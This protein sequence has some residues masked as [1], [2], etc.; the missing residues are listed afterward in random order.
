MQCIS[1][2]NGGVK[3]PVF[4][5]KG[6][7]KMADKDLK[8]SVI[9]KVALNIQAISTNTTTAGAIIDTLG[10]ESVTFVLQ[11]G[12]LTD[13]AYTPLIEDGD[14]SGLSDA[15]AVADDF[16]LGTEAGAAFA[17]TDDNTTKRIGYVGKKRYVRVS[18]V[19][20]SVSSGGTLGGVCVLGS[21]ITR[22]T[23]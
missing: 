10:Y 16:L 19:S 3:P 5:F 23:A 21:A 12:T 9:S 15:A 22:P 4:F 18:V 14:N 11:S 13:G 8:N 6:V 1:N 2:Y 7:I 20:T 17:L